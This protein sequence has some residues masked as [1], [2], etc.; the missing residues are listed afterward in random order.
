MVNVLL[1]LVTT[2]NL[3][4]YLDPDG[5]VTSLQRLT[6]TASCPMNLQLFP[7]DTQTC[8][9]DIE[10]YGY[11]TS[12]VN[13]FWKND[14]AWEDGND[15]LATVISFG[16]FTLPQYRVVGYITTISEP[17]PLDQRLIFKVILKRNIGFYLINIIIPAMLIVTI[18]WVS[19]W[20][21]VGS[22][23]ARVA[24]GVT[25]ML[26]MTHGSSNESGP[27][28]ACL[29]QLINRLTNTS[30][31]DKR[32]R[33]KFGKGAV[34]V[35][36]TMHVLSISD[37]SEVDMDFTLD[38]DLS[39]VWTDSRLAFEMLETG[40]KQF[41]ILETSA[42]ESETLY[43]G[44]DYMNNIWQP[45]T[46][47]ANEKKSSFHTVT[48][49]NSVVY[50]NADGQVTSEQRLSV[51]A[52]C[53]MNLQL[54][55]LDTQTSIS[56]PTSLD[57]RLILKVILKRNIGF[58]LINII[59]PAM[60]IVIISW[61][62]F[63]LNIG[64]A[65]ARVTLG[66]T[67]MLTMITLMTIMNDSMPKVSYVKSMD[68]FLLFCLVM[69]FASLVEYAVASYLNKNPTWKVTRKYRIS[70]EKIDKF[71]RLVF[72]LVFI[73]FQIGYWSVMIVLSS[74]NGNQD[75][76]PFRVSTKDLQFSL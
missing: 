21:N 73:T 29:S 20:L 26:T 46:F 43:L 72:P 45:D 25:T 14:S 63:W 48:T 22:T 66:V 60:L 56:E 1:F 31:Y 17:T 54:F 2:Q 41:E 64:S 55:P 67:T 70:P 75:Y 7:L 23:P 8:E 35:G 38:F 40:F 44:S 33:P 3:I 65:P 58:Y 4:A 53:P 62:S 27:N 71:S 19:F 16:E 57:Q 13:Y 51:T 39:Q 18:S 28:T 10:S 15:D 61:V 42:K 12:E 52:S 34:D 47:F 37:V 6:V 30:I 68:I 5:Q 11:Y 49:P 36:I 32:L 24:L 74:Q 69:I 50:L 9:L 76:R 59:I